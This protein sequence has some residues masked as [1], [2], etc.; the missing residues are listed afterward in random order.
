[1]K[2]GADSVLIVRISESTRVEKFCV[3]KS[4]IQD[5]VSFIGEDNEGKLLP[6]LGCSEAIF[7]VTLEH[8]LEQQVKGPVNRLMGL[9]RK[10]CLKPTFG[11]EVSQYSSQILVRKNVLERISS[12]AS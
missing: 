12:V 8:H 9:T 6:N 11:V 10:E 2:E 4:R 5:H 7:S 1:M 3:L